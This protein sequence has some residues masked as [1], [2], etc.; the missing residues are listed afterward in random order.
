MDGSR[1]AIQ[2]VMRSRN[3]IRKR[4][5]S[6]LQALLGQLGRKDFHETQP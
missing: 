6:Q 4:I 5:K 3:T 1:R 2:V